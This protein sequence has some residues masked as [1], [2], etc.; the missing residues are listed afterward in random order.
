MREAGPGPGEA[1]IW[2]ALGAI[3]GALLRWSLTNTLV[4]NTL[5]CF[6]VGV[7]GLLASPSPRRRLLLGIG[8]AGSLTTFST[9]MLSLVDDL[10][11]DQW[12]ALLFHVLRDGSLGVGALGLG[13]ALHRWLS[14]RGRGCPPPVK[15]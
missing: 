6:V 5:G 1:M 15:R 12:G 7:S 9:W 13:A 3:P 4:A 8:F 14:R 2:V 10:R 11:R